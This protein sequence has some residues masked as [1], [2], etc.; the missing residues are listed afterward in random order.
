M[1]DFQMEEK[2]LQIK[3]HKVNMDGFETNSHHSRG[4]LGRERQGVDSHETKTQRYRSNAECYDEHDERIVQ[5]AM[6][7]RQDHLKILMGERIPRI[8]FRGALPRMLSGVG[9]T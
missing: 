1:N 5:N 8:H 3:E 9:S 6:D 4:K 2:N 7:S